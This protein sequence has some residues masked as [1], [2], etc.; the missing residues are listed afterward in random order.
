MKQ[1]PYFDI[2]VVGQ[3]LRRLRKEN[4]LSVREVRDYLGF[5]S[6]QA[7]YKYENGS[8]YPQVET[9]FALMK[10]YNASLD[11]IITP[12]NEKEED[13]VSSSFFVFA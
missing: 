2:K 8:G 5:E 12:Y 3:N 9:M 4:N 1:R 6:D 11:D 10:L 7:V 13:L